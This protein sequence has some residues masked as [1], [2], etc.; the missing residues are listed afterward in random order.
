MATHCTSC[1]FAPRNKMKKDTVRRVKKHVWSRLPE[2]WVCLEL[3]NIYTPFLACFTNK[4]KTIAS[5]TTLLWPIHPKLR[6]KVVAHRPKKDLE[7][8]Q[9]Q[10]HET[11]QTLNVKTNLRRRYTAAGRPLFHTVPQTLPSPRPSLFL[12][13]ITQ[14][15][16]NNPFPERI[17][18]ERKSTRCH[19]VW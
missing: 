11:P 14:E 8:N 12:Q 13:T 4:Y 5:S 15:M 7:K 18:G 9:T 6:V 16:R 17:I 10:R 3:V 19:M 2:W 1:H